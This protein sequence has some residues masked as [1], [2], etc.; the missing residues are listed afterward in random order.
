MQ[1]AGLSDYEL[2]NL[3]KSSKTKLNYYMTLWILN[4]AIIE[5][6]IL[7]IIC[8]IWKTYSKGYLVKL[9]VIIFEFFITEN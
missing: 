9:F 8:N 7:A 1:V 6:A 4:G 2:L 3:I 5:G